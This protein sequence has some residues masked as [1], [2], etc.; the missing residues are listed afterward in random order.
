[1]ALGSLHWT[2][3]G[4]RHVSIIVKA[5]FALRHEAAMVITNPAPIVERDEHRDG[6]PTKSL[7]AAS[8][9]VPFRPRADVWLTGHAHA[10]RDRA[11]AATVARLGLYRAGETLLEKTVHVVG[12]RASAGAAPQPFRRMAL[13]Y[14]AAYGGIGF[15]D[16]PVGVGADERLLYPNLIDPAQTERPGCFAPISRYWKVRRGDLDAAVRRAVNDA[17]PEVPAGFDFA[18]FQAAP[19]DQRVAYLQGDEWLVLEGMSPTQLRVHSRLPKAR[20]KARWIVGDEPGD[21]V[22]MVADTLAI[23]ADAQTCAI[24]WRGTVRVGVSDELS[25]VVVAGG[26]DVDGRG[27][28]WSLA[29]VQ[30]VVGPRPTPPVAL[31]RSGITLV[32][33]R[34]D[35][36]E[37]LGSTSVDVQRPEPSDHTLPGAALPEAGLAG[38]RRVATDDWSPADGWPSYGLVGDGDEV[39]ETKTTVTL[40][41]AEPTE[42]G[43]R[44]PLPVDTE[45][46]GG[47]PEPDEAWVSEPTV[48]P[49]RTSRSVPPA[50]FDVDAYVLSLR[51]AGASEADIQA[52]LGLL[53]QRGD[54]R[55]D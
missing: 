40:A 38:Y 41:E 53:P 19:P 21:E 14:E 3:G 31:A 42:R 45:V 32:S 11:V 8:D 13:V 29:R 48:E 10:P 23:D 2:S 12:S 52:L 51:R 25:R 50:P 18:Y 22:A 15:D 54:R 9:V 39:T 27:V 46:G 35:V 20:A 43:R 7:V 37:E 6:D 5:R 1:V 33:A 28:D 49:L 26:V 24:T 16:N 36:S 17:V 44:I 34:G 4:Q 47:P 55:G 30:G